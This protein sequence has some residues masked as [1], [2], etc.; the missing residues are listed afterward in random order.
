VSD[1][2]L[3][4]KS[5]YSNSVRRNNLDI[6]WTKDSNWHPPPIPGGGGYAP[7]PFREKKKKKKKKNKIKEINLS[8]SLEKRKTK[9]MISRTNI[10]HR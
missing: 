5:P 8:L 10:S 2:A 3:V 9:S 4:W 6:F 7:D 1:A